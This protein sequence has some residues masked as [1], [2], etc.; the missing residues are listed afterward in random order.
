MTMLLA[1]DPSIRSTGVA[2]FKDGQLVAVSTIKG[3]PKGDIAVRAINIA[4]QVLWWSDRC[5]STPYRINELVFEWPQA[6]SVA[7]SKGSAS[8]LFPWWG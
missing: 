2:M 4:E 1:I 8:D 6:Y 5:T 7:K 3:I